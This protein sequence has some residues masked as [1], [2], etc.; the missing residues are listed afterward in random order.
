MGTL[1]Q[2]GG[3][4]VAA[5]PPLGHATRTPRRATHQNISDKALGYRL[6]CQQ[7]HSRAAHRI[8]VSDGS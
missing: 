1:R 7:Y 8:A 6:S 2:H 4:R 3:D 5:L